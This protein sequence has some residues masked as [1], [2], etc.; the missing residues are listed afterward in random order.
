[1][2][3]HIRGE[4]IEVVSDYKYLRSIIDCHGENGKDIEERIGKPFKDFGAL[5]KPVFMDGNLSNE[6]KK[7]VYRAIVPHTPVMARRR[8]SPRVE[9]I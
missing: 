3:N 1:M 9:Y 8:I 7:L 2:P 5:R 4:A 6:R